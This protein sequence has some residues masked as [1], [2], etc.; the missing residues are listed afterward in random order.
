MV[1]VGIAEKL[2]NDNVDEKVA[3][4]PDND[5]PTK[6][7]LLII[8]FIFMFRIF[9]TVLSFLFAINIVIPRQ[10]KY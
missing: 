8:V 5:M 9:N 7:F 4:F 10:A 1:K 6:D 2:G 3:M